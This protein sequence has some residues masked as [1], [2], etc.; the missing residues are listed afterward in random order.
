M[1]PNDLLAILC[2]PETH[3]GLTEA[4]PALIEQVN[5]KITGG[6]LRNRGG[7]LVQERIDSGLVRE[8][9]QWLYPIRQ[10][11]PILLIDESLP[12]T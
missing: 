4:D 7:Q 3:Q 11:I 6:Q 12:L 5:E 8:D 9:R 2:C 10:E 1:I